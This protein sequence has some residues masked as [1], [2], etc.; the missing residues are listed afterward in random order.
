MWPTYDTLVY[1]DMGGNFVPGLATAWE[2]SEDGLTY[3]FNLREGV[4]FH[5][6]TPFN[7]EAVKFS[8]DR[9]VDPE[10]GSRNAIFLIGPY[11]STE[12]VDDY[13]VKVHLKE[14]YAPF[15][16]VVSQV[17]LAIV[18][19]TAVRKWGIN[20]YY[21]HQVGTGPFRWVEYV[22]KDHVTL[23]RNPDYNWAPAIFQHQGPAYLDGIT[24]KFIP[25]HMT[26]LGTLETG[27]TDVIDEIPV[28]E[29]ERLKADP[30]F[31]TL[32]A[33]KTGM[34]DLYMINTAKAPT[35]ELAVRQ[36]ILHTVDRENLLKVVFGGVYSKAHGPITRATFG[37]DPGLEEMYPYD[38]D[39]AK[40]LLDEAG[41]KVNPATGIREKDGMPLK[42]IDTHWKA[43]EKHEFLQAE[44]KKVGIDVEI[45]MVA[46]LAYIQA[47]GKGEANLCSITQS[48]GDPSFLNGFF[49]SD[50]KYDWTRHH[51]EGLDELL[52]EGGKTL[53]PKKRADIYKEIQQTL[54]QGAALLPIY[55]L[56]ASF[57]TRAEVKGL[58]FN[59]R[60]LPIF[61]D[62]YVRQ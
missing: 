60:G 13:T 52:V 19:P 25:E 11:E 59:V 2:V 9:I 45:N 55:D 14:V 1:K 56:Q 49:M 15:M 50:A 31:Q 61:H 51:P 58:A 57:A 48:G 41:W 54:M 6:G 30:T 20:E 53:D 38:P 23:E 37:Y 47:C 44:L 42:L 5:D 7:A 22:E 40:A 8:F 62:V 18:S 43:L 32:S 17:W 35:D 33:I 26:R 21:L 39:K 12:V 16:D 3:T 46:P 29:W 24:F 34:P 28:L 27:E 36:A 10:T 4:K